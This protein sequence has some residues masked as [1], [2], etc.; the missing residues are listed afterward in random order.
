MKKLAR[1]LPILLL[2]ACSLAPKPF[3]SPPAASLPDN[4]LPAG[5][6]SNPATGQKWLWLM[7]NL[8]TDSALHSDIELVRRASALG[9]THLLVSDFKF[10]KWDYMG[11]HYTQNVLALKQACHDN[12]MQ[13]WVTCAPMGYANELLSRDANLAEGVPVYKAQFTVEGL[14]LKADDPDLK[15]INGDF[16]IIGANVPKPAT[17]EISDYGKSAILDRNVTF[18]NLP[19]L[20][21]D[22]QAP[23][24][25]SAEA[26]AA[27]ERPAAASVYQNVEVKPFHYYHLHAKIKTASK[28]TSAPQ[29]QILADNASALPNT[30]IGEH[31]GT[32]RLNY[33]D[34]ILL[35]NSDWQDYD[36]TFNSLEF[37]RILVKLPGP[38][39]RGRN[40]AADHLAPS[41]YWA[42]LKLEPA[43]FVNLVRRAGAP[44]SITSPDGKTRY[45]EG[46]DVEFITDPLLGHSPQAGHYQ[47]WHTPPVAKIPAGSRLHEG[48]KVLVSY[49]HTALIHADQAMCCMQ[50]PKVMQL[51]RQQLKECESR[52][53]PDGYFMGYD[54]LRVQGYDQSCAETHKPLAQLLAENV[55]H[56]VRIIHQVAPGRPIAVWS[57]LFD[58]FHN[59]KPDGKRYYLTKGVCPWYGAWLGLPRDVIIMNWHGHDENRIAAMKF[60][61]DHGY[62]QI[63]SAYYDADVTKFT[64][65]LNE[66]SHIK[67]IAGTMYTT[68]TSNFSQ[69]EPYTTLL[70]NWT[71][72]AP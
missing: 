2:T 40:A 60:F 12:H 25:I 65:R 22:P 59:A 38:S 19:A 47:A 9:F 34:V 56:S 71:P 4:T 64:P 8:N 7:T 39:R 13:F 54:E 6:H 49:Y 30:D 57:D 62:S 11:D 70:K 15:L 61:A 3:N 32:T 66:A 45:K 5:I 43:E 48:D 69:M 72:P 52:I 31:T 41:I 42:D 21:M 58:P 46:K 27:G 20:R 23:A 55:A 14:R 50:E 24:E 17:W 18:N 10:M 53:H 26:R 35:P 51:I 36:I 67:N 33:Q 29:I 63:L 16:S 37:S 44:L 28:S 1:L 68:W